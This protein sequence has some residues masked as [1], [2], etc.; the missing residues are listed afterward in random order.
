MPSGNKTSAFTVLA[1]GIGVVTAAAIIVL[2]IVITASAFKTAI[3]TRT[4]ETGN[5]LS[6]LAA[7]SEIGTAEAVLAFGQGMKA[8]DTV[9]RD[10][11]AKETAL[12]GFVL[13]NMRG[14]TIIQRSFD[15]G[16]PPGISSQTVPGFI[17]HDKH[18]DLVMAAPVSNVFGEQIGYLIASFSTLE[19]FS[20]VMKHSFGIS[21]IAYTDRTV[22]G[23]LGRLIK[24]TFRPSGAVLSVGVTVFGGRAGAVMLVVPY[25][26]HGVIL[27]A[28]IVVCTVLVGSIITGVRYL[29]INR[30]VPVTNSG[31]ALTQWND[32]DR[33]QFVSALFEI[34]DTVLNLNKRFIAMKK[35]T[36]QEGR[37][38]ALERAG[39]MKTDKVE[40]EEGSKT[41]IIEADVSEREIV[42][43][44]Y[45]DEA[46][47][48]SLDI[49]RYDRINAE[50]MLQK[51]QTFKKGK[52]SVIGDVTK[53]LVHKY[54]VN[55][56]VAISEA[57]K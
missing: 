30:A 21:R 17:R 26:P 8:V 45:Y 15:S 1:F 33:S 10:Y 39:A 52:T 19:H 48:Y 9:I 14:R 40:M 47:Y 24:V 6:S 38:S 29:L 18:T 56:Y 49:S 28:F 35:K 27:I 51:K 3:E 25:F 55:D 41:A 37:P 43:N 53:T 11:K 23:A 2:F 5:S 54:E 42:M 22:T 36:A 12:T 32:E 31:V 34:K 46:D 20:G 4:K 7:R 13:V 50:A 57:P 44:D 16:S